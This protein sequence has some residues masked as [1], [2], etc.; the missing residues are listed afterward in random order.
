MR[1][2]VVHFSPTTDF[3]PIIAK[4]PVY[5]EMAVSNSTSGK[6]SLHWIQVEG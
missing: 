3:L 1:P 2:L 4:C 5:V 6:T